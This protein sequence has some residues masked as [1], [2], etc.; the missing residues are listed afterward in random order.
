MRTI[1]L[2]TD[3]TFVHRQQ[4]SGRRRP[5]RREGI[6]AEFGFL[7][8]K[9]IRL[10][11]PSCCDYGDIEI[12]NRTFYTC[13]TRIRILKEDGLKYATVETPDETRNRHDDFMS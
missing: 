9:K 12:T 5:I 2:L 13:H 8:R 10:L 7:P 11:P 6:P 1:I 4:V 3:H